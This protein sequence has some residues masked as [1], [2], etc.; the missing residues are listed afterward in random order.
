MSTNQENPAP[1][2]REERSGR[3]DFKACRPLAASLP[4]FL[5]F[6][7]PAAAQ[8]SSAPEAEQLREELRR[9]KQDYGQ[10]IEQLEKRLQ[11]LEVTPTPTNVPPVT[12]TV[13]VS[14]TN[15]PANLASNAAVVRA[16]ANQEFQNTTESRQRAVLAESGPLRNRLEQVLQNYVDFN[17]YFRAGYGRDNEGG[18]QVAFQAPGAFSKYRLGNEAETYGELTLGKNFYAPGMFKLDPELRQDGTPDGPVARVQTTIS[19]Y[20]PYQDLLS[21][22][23]TEFGLPE[24]WAAIGNV[25]AA[26]PSMNFW[27]G[28][29]F[30]RRHDIHISDFF[31]YNMSGAGGGMEGLELPFGKLALAWIG[32]AS[33]SGVS[34]VPAPDAENKAGFSKANWDLRLYD[35]PLPLGTGEFGLVYAR[36]DSG[37]D[38]NGNSAPSSDGVAFTF[39]HTRNHFISQDG[40]NKFS[41]QFGTGA[42]KTFTSGFENFTTNNQVFIRPDA[43]DSW[44]LR[45]TE[46]FVANV[47]EH[48]SIGPALVYQ[49]TDYGDEGGRVYWASAGVRPVLHFNQ[50]LSLAFE[51]GVD[52]VKNDEAGTKGNLYKLTLAPQVSL[53]GRFMSRPVLR[54]FVTYAHW[55]DDFVG[56]VGGNDYLTQDDGLTYGVQM[57]VWW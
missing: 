48:F 7:F 3:L 6:P 43:R 20:N 23:G 51:G 32:A 24:A 55:S 13:M 34:D 15:A 44:R 49:M 57:E 45:A 56:Q 16:F 22:S 18:P 10:R 42:A 27:A 21:S 37:L 8:S 53:G 19:V 31:Y 17:G 39:L 52:W 1:T 35:V 50:Y 4:V 26:Q 29:R 14:N 36:E 40:A 54:A 5:A 38:A 47:N 11:S 25:V 9:L 12:A 28:Y 2:V 46:C 30:Y 41:F 33:S